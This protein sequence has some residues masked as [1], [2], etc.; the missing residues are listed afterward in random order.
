MKELIQLATVVYADSQGSGGLL[1]QGHHK[2]ETAVGLIT[3]F[4]LSLS[5][6]TT[7]PAHPEREPLARIQ[8]CDE[9]NGWPE[10]H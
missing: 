8:A 2:K 7:Q 4:F 9:S 10:G 5:V 6:D 1:F 3:Y